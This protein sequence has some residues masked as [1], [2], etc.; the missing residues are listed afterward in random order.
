MNRR[1]KPKGQQPL[2]PATVPKPPPAAPAKQSPSPPPPPSAAPKP[3]SPPLSTPSSRVRAEWK[4]FQPWLAERRAERDKRLAEARAPKPGTRVNIYRKPPPPTLDPAAQLELELTLNTALCRD[5][6]AE[7]ERRLALKGL[8]SEDWTD[9]TSA[10]MR[11]V[12]DAFMAPEPPSPSTDTSGRYRPYGLTKES[13]SATTLDLGSEAPPS[14][15]APAPTSKQDSP[16][17]AAGSSKLNQSQTLHS[18]RDQTRFGDISNQP[19]ARVRADSFSRQAYAGPDQRES[20]WESVM[21]QRAHANYA[22]VQPT[23]AA[24]T[25]QQES[26]WNTTM[27][28][29]K[30]PAPPPPPEPQE[31]L[32]EAKMRGGKSSIPSS[33]TTPFP[34]SDATES[35]W[36]SYQKGRTAGLPKTA[37]TSPE[38]QESPWEA[39]MKAR[40]TGGISGT[41]S[42]S[43]SLSGEVAADG[44]WDSPL[45][46]MSRSMSSSSTDLRDASWQDIPQ[47]K[48]RNGLNKPFV[49]S[50]LASYNS[51]NPASLPPFRVISPT[52]I[53]LEDGDYV[54][55]GFEGLSEA[56]LESTIRHFYADVADA[57]IE[58]RRQLYFPGTDAHRRAELLEEF[59]SGLVETAREV[60][61]KWKQLRE[62]AAEEEERRQR[63][64]AESMKKPLWKNK[65]QAAATSSFAPSPPP[66]PAPTPTPAP[67]PSASNK[68]GAKKGGKNAKVQEVTPEPPAQEET[69]RL[70]GGFEDADASSGGWNNI[71]SAGRNLWTSG[72]PARSSS[73]APTK[74]PFSGSLNGKPSSTPWS[75]G[76]KKPSGLGRAT[77]ADEEDEEEDDEEAQTERVAGE[78]RAAENLAQSMA[79]PWKWTNSDTSTPGGRSGTPKPATPAERERRAGWGGGPASKIP[80]PSSG[81]GGQFWVPGGG[82]LDDD[83]VKSMMAAAMQELGD[84]EDVGDTFNT[85]ASYTQQARVVT[86]RPDPRKRTV[87][88]S[89]R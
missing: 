46:S 68:K 34:M 36:D 14:H 66:A 22:S 13:L 60:W 72:T 24:S 57:E 42:R 16:W 4:A 82:A 32:W 23:A 63:L 1:N 9:L 30:T 39:S 6:H 28:G 3:P 61:E 33:N 5:A 79:S 77:V 43:T 59:T 67:P 65:A 47:G 56:E 15:P 62:K 78:K 69:S 50:P 19:N 85:M 86:A 45:G 10:E 27:S 37:T 64:M 40:A 44:F 48:T 53:E 18:S 35:P 25:G 8:R 21:R 70:P 84:E 17:G 87:S 31:S 88:S 73:P 52:S 76:P 80:P 54:K 55:A 71:L 20:L 7:F 58:F 89:K 74:N 49:S 12:E 29:R 11:E 75:A 26:L 51:E 41:R 83:P 38:P 2:K 81:G